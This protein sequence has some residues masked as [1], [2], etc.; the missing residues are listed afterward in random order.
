MPT[1][2]VLAA[3]EE[4][5][6]GE[7]GLSGE[8]YRGN[9]IYKIEVFLN[10]GI[11]RSWKDSIIVLQTTKSLLPWSEDLKL[12]EPNAIRKMPNIRAQ[13][14]GSLLLLVILVEVKLQ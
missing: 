13:G 9:L 6:D 3:I 1:L 11:F 2:Q 7:T 14:L 5:S 8:C 12:M 10:S 4:Q